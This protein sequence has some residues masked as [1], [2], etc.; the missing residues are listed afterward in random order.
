MSAAEERRRWA[1]GYLRRASK[2]GPPYGSPEWLAM[3]EGPEKWASVVSAAEA[4]MAYDEL[5]DL[6]LESYRLAAKQGEDAAF[7]A[8][9][10]AHRKDWTGTGFRPDP[11]IA[12]DIDREWREWVGG[13]A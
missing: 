13:A 2:P 5:V 3:P 9:A 12:D 8:R 6:E 4:L 10:A 11:A 1:Y 7:R